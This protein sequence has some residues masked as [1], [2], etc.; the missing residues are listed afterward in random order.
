MAHLS[1]TILDVLPFPVIGAVRVATK[2]APRLC[3]VSDCEN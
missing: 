3:K 2:A 1:P